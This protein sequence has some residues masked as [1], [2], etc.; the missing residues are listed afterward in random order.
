MNLAWGR[1][2]A[3]NSVPA[4]LSQHNGIIVT[5]VSISVKS[6]YSLGI[7]LIILTV[8]AY[9]PAL[10]AG[11]IWDDDD[12][13]TNN[14]T[15]RDAQGLMHI[16]TDTQ[17]NWQYYPMVFTTFWV[18]YHAWELH[19]F[20][21][22][23]DNVLLHGIS[24]VLLW[25]LLLRFE[26]SPLA[27]WLA[28]GIFAVH[29][30]EVESVAWVTERK[31]VLCAVFFLA[32]MLVYFYPKRSRVLYALAAL[33]F[34]FAMM[35][36][37]VAATWPVA[38]LIIQWWRTG[39][40]QRRDVIAMIPFLIIGVTLGLLTSLIEYGQV[41]AGGKDWDFSFADRCLI[42]GR[43]IG[44]YAAKAIFPYS[45][46]FIYP[47]WDL[48][49]QRPVILGCAIVTLVV[50]SVLLS[51]TRKLGRGPAAAALLFAITLSPALGFVN[52]YPMRFSFVADHF[53]YLAIIA[54]IVP[55]AFLAARRLGRVAVIL[56]VPL[57]GLT[58]FQ[59]GIYHDSVSLWTDTVKKNPQSWMAHGNL[60]QA[61]DAAGQTD[62]AAQEFANSTNCAPVE[63]E[64]WWR[65]GEFHAKYK[66]YDQ[67]AHY[68][69]YALSLDPAYLP[70][71][72]DLAKVQEI[73]GRR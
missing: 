51:S 58:F 67:A 48:A 15:L 18:E 26:F 20:G 19:P 44:F 12:Y 38:V 11:F 31:N 72:R 69:K 5:H 40:V 36:K 34:M 13:V 46:T 16:W 29:P 9:L 42:A 37:T 24:A 62:L 22:H 17:A 33:L 27:A 71:Q 59:C 10:R 23:F 45:L 60:G 2:P 39:R 47:R 30:V 8:L 70:A 68:F 41:G 66:H 7:L 49:L 14:L 57:A 56:L 55:V 64:V 3:Y 65:L 52:Y 61:Y 43:A 73:E 6:K 28:A 50:Y 1:L 21:Y 63:P 35:S 25:Q 53:Q 4:F 32:A 54:V